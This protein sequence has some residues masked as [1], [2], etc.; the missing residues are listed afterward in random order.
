ML[1]PAACYR[2]WKKV[3]FLTKIS[4]FDR[5]FAVW[6]KFLFLQEF[7]FLTKILDL[8]FFNLDPKFWFLTSILNKISILSKSSVFTGIL[9]FDENIRWSKFFFLIFN[10]NCFFL[11]F[12]QN[13][14]FWP[15]SWTK[16]FSYNPNSI[17]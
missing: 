15:R 12:N 6:Q 5:H 8:K 10:Q 16:M 9:I 3:I 2:R 4:I 17:I 13:F 11:I 1:K 14:D 7:R